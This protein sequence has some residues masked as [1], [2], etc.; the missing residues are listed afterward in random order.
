MLH[1]SDSLSKGQVYCEFK[2]A[3]FSCKERQPYMPTDE[4]ISISKSIEKALEPVI[5]LVSMLQFK[6]YSLL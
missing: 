4:E 5:L 6:I 2:Y 1:K 3:T